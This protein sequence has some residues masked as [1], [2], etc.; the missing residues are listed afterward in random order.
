[1]K[2]SAYEYLEFLEK[3]ESYFYKN[4][5]EFITYANGL[6]KN[7]EDSEYNELKDAVDREYKVSLKNRNTCINIIKNFFYK[8]SPNIIKQID[9]D[10]D[11]NNIVF[12]NADEINEA[13]RISVV[14]DSYKIEILETTKLDEVF[15]LVREYAHLFSGSILDVSGYEKEYKSIYEEA[16]TSLVEF[17]LARHLMLNRTLRSDAL[18]Y[19]YRKIYNSIYNMNDSYLLLMY[20]GL[21]MED[22]SDDEIVKALGS[23]EMVEKLDNIIKSKSPCTDYISNIG[24]MLA[25]KCANNTSN[26]FDEVNNA[27]IKATDMDLK[28]FEDILPFELNERVSAEEITYYI[29]N[30]K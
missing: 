5:K 30:T 25:I 2:N 15:A 13:S 19:I 6:N 29:R 12:M 9:Y 10:I 1:M 3:E 22:R 23:K 26:I 7:L 18:T 8:V 11:K 14:G 20:L 24:T 21:L 28:Y 4:F 17:A 27:F 16:I